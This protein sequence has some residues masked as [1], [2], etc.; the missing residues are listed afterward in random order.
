[1]VKSFVLARRKM[2]LKFV[3]ASCSSFSFSIKGILS[4]PYVKQCVSLK[5]ENRKLKDRFLDR[6]IW[7]TIHL[8]TECL[9]FQK[10]VVSW[11]KLHDE[12]QIWKCQINCMFLLIQHG[13]ENDIPFL[14]QY[15]Q[16]WSVSFFDTWIISPFAMGT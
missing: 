6:Y 11:S 4:K 2:V 7:C 15:L 13:K 12:T 16:N 8:C 5:E 3:A 1:M 14:P 9:N 10:Q